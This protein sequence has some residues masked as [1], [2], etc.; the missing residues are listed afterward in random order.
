MTF[1]IFDSNEGE[2]SGT[3]IEQSRNHALKHSWSN[4]ATQFKRVVDSS[5]DFVREY[6]KC[7]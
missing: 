7:P 4:T 6:V 1:L 3:G 2:K 5:V